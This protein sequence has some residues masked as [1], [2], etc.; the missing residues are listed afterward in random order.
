LWRDRVATCYGDDA[1]NKA[2]D[3]LL[4]IAIIEQVIALIQWWRNR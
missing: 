2:V 1:D 3:P 4:I